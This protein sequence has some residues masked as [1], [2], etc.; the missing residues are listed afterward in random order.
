MARLPKE[1]PTTILLT[2]YRG[3]KLTMSELH[4]RTR[5][6]TITILNHVN[7]LIKA[8]LLEEEREGDFPKRRVIKVSGEGKR[9]A[10]LLNLADSY[11]T[12]ISELVEMGAKAGRMASYRETIATLGN[13]NTT[14]DFALAELHIK[15]LEALSG[16]LLLIG[17]GL[18]DEQKEDAE[19][20]K[21]WSAKLEGYYREG[22]RL[23]A[24]NDVRGTAAAV[25]RALSEFGGSSALMKKV[26]D[27][28]R[29]RGQEELAKYV[30]FLSPK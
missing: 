8:G 25:S 18:P 19:A 7:G 14:R 6:S 30:E 24:A 1:V 29:E 20:L 11:A 4:E 17:R 22:R 15:E 28:V 2:V 5:F 3:G 26:L 16:G 27:F 23:L 13:P 10:S 21:A 12:G 9:V